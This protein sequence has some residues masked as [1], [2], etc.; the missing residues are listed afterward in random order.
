MSNAHTVWSVG[1]ALAV[2]AAGLVAPASGGPDPGPAP[3]RRAA[4]RFND[5]AVVSVAAPTAFAW[6]PDG[7]LLVTAKA[8]QLVVSNGDRRSV[9]LDIRSRTCDQGERGL[10]GVAVDPQFESNHFVYLFYTHKVR[11]SCGDRGPDPQSR[12]GRFVLG[13]DG[14]ARPGDE[15]VILDHLAS[16]TIH[17]LAGDLEFG[18]DGLLYV[19]VGD[20]VCTVGRRSRCGGLDSNAQRRNVPLGKILRVDRNGRPAQDNPFM[21][22]RGSRRCTRPSSPERGTGPCQEVFALGLRNPFRIARRPGSSAFYVGDVGQ[23]TWEEIDR[24]GRGRNYGWPAREGHCARDS[25]TRCKHDARFVDPIY[26]YEHTGCRSITGGAFVPDG[27]WPGFDGSFLFADFTCGKI[28]RLRTRPGGGFARSVLLRGVDGPTHLRFGPMEGGTALYYASFFGDQVRRVS[29]SQGNTAPIASF[30]YTPDGTVVTFDGSESSD[31]DGDPLS[32]WHWTFGDGASTTTTTPRVTH[33]YAQAGTVTASLTV[34]DAGGMTSPSASMTVYPGEHPPDV[35]ITSPS[36]DARFAVGQ[37]VTLSAGAT[38]A[39]D[40][41]LPDS[42]LTWEV[43]LR[44]GNHFHPHVAPTPG[45]SILTTYPPPEELEATTKSWLVATV[46]ATDSHGVTSTVRRR[47][48]PRTVVLTFDTRPEGGALVV[49]GD[50]HKAAF[51]AT[52]WVRYVIPVKAPD[53]RIA[54]HAYVFRDWSDGRRRSH[55][56]RTPATP[57]TYVAH[58]RRR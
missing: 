56:I 52:S 18:E 32:Q 33:T 44:H 29:L 19:S 9:A 12:V 21:D 51:R 17:H 34:T 45:S 46:T 42:S 25:A 47:L 58:F 4:P 22:N 30:D 55:S 43:R 16:P 14:I 53:Q 11:G 35:E 7:R 2:S 3:G 15:R 26:D 37:T 5:T 27:L 38:D 28:F 36:V 48:L 57:T 20:G 13:D 49:E 39:E 23:H 31:P 50:R 8:G 41:T 6:T 54:G 1:V 40:G 10:L 24:L